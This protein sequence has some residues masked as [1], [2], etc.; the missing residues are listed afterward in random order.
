MTRRWSVGFSVVAAIT[1]LSLLAAGTGV[2]AFLKAPAVE[3]L[4]PLLGVVQ[5]AVSPISGLLEGLGRAGGMAEENAALRGQLEKALAE[6]SALREAGEE[7]RQLRALLNFERDNPGRDYLAGRIIA[8]DPNGL[9]RSVVIDR[10]SEHGVQKGMVLVVDRG[11]VGRVLTVYPRAAKVLLTTDASSAVNGVVQRSRV[12]G[13]AVGRPDGTLALRYVD[14]DADVKEGDVVVTSGLGGGYPRGIT[15]GTVKR[16][17]NEDQASFK[18]VQIAPAA[19]SGPLEIA[20][21]MLDFV[22][23]E[24][25]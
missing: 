4:T 7:N 6:T 5:V 21:I 10:G 9:V 15:L 8:N 25:P 22:P 12:Q 24:L 18:E 20:L 14:K 16:V 1:I 17:T 23:G 13:V 3:V 11:M 2:P 19:T